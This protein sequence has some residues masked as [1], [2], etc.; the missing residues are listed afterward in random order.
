[1]AKSVDT[2]EVLGLV[3]DI[4]RLFRKKPLK[5]LPKGDI[6]M[7]DSCPLARGIDVPGIEVIKSGLTVDS[8]ELVKV[9]EKKR[10]ALLGKLR[11]PESEENPSVSGSYFY[12]SSPVARFVKLFDNGKIPE[13]VA[14]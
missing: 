10:P 9:I 12:K 8:Y 2:A 3:N 11:E 14:E 13:L 4:R 7:V 5:K 6:A 1:M